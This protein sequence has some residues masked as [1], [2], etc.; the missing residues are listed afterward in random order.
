MKK[1]NEP[2]LLRIILSGEGGQGIKLISSIV[3]KILFALGWD[4]SLA[5]D[6]D[7]VVRGGKIVSFMVVS[8]KGSVPNPIIEEADYLFKLS[9]KGGTYPSRAIFTD[10]I[11]AYYDGSA[12]TRDSTQK[13]NYK[14]KRI[15]SEIKDTARHTQ[16][17]PFSRLAIEKFQN[18][19][20]MNMLVLGKLLNVLG[21]DSKT[22]DWKHYLPE[23]FRDT[24]IAAIEYGYTL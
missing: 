23:K 13:H 15:I 21:I 19:K 6:Y 2:S 18:Q 4:L 5:L 11:D 20:V 9:K 10:Q 1:K 3:A 16:V 24:N 14:A 22:V 7:T 8:K 17:I 12:R